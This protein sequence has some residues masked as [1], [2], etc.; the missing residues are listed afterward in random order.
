MNALWSGNYVGVKADLE[1]PSSGVISTELSARFAARHAQSSRMRSFL[2]L[3]K[4]L[5]DALGVRTPASVKSQLRRI[6]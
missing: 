3:G 1:L 5:V 2:G 6:F 4:K